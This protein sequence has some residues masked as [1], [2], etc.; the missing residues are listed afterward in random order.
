M[1]RDGLPIGAITA[2]SNLVGGI[3]DQQ[4]E[5]VKT[6]AD[7]AVIA[8]ENARLFKEL[9]ARNRDLTA[10]GEILRVISRSPTN[11]QPVL[12]TLA[13]SAAR[14][15]E[16]LDVSIL[17]R[18]GD[19]LLFVAHHGRIPGGRVGEF[20]L[21]LGRGTVAGRSVMDARAVHTADVQAEAEEFP[22]GSENARRM[23]FRT[24]LSVPLLRE[25][26]AI[27]AIVLR[28]TEAQLFTE[29]QLALLQTFADQAVI[30]IENVRLFTELQEKNAALTQAHA[31][32]T[33]ALEQQTATAEILR[34]ISSSPTDVQPVFEAIVRGA[35]RLCKGFFGAVFRYEA[36]VVDVV[37]ECN[38]PQQGLEALRRIYPG[39]PAPDTAPGRA[40][41]TREVVHIHDQANSEEFTA[42]VTRTSGFRTNIAIPML[43]NGQPIGVIA[44]ARGQVQPFS[45]PEIQLLKTFADQAVIAIE[46]VRLF[47]ELEA[48]NRDLTATGEILRVISTSPTDEQPVFEAI[49]D[50]ALRLF[51]AV[52]VAVI[53]YDGELISL[54]AARGG[55]P[56]S[57][58]AA[59]ELYRAPH[60]PMAGYP[61]EQSVL[62]KVMH[63]VADVE[64]DPSCSD[65]FRRHARKRG[66]HSLLSIPMLRGPDAVGAIV[67]SRAQPG[68]FLTAEMDL[69]RTF[70]DQA[71]IAIENV[72]LFKELEARTGELTRS[73]D[74]LTALSE[75]GRAVSSTLDLETVLTTIVSLPS[76]CR[77]WRRARS[78]STT[79]WLRC[80]TCGRPRTCLRSSWR[81][82]GPW[83][84]RRV[85]E[86]P[87]VWRS[88]ASPSRFPTWRPRRLTAVGCG[89]SSCGWATGHCWRCR[90]SARIT[91]S[92]A[93][94]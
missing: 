35:V 27:G 71:V 1:L 63:H 32:M 7:Q 50:S 79:R 4:I 8:I 72:R 67:V 44:V 17:R 64:T 36:N 57:A 24:V 86:P 93:W 91:S 31:Q 46:N 52:G 75:V 78:T 37:A 88:R 3:S 92:A 76:S 53:R 2:A 59:M 6:F 94:S 41:L 28:R 49:A 26:V 48:R 56:G 68:G 40:L 83:R 23:G 66:F 19:R 22:E 82:R 62:T 30:A 10:T 15:C 13:E 16:A 81:S 74:Q 14:L 21:P 55:A 18:E 60:W 69:L 77:A 87:G 73:V 9:E 20:T 58:A 43:R 47:K 34:V 42:T 12:D 54:A 25:G 38:V 29:R 90:S 89:T 11:I 80:S 51:E 61:P 70:A 39:P 84:S 65:E 85:R 33:E 5:L 45:E